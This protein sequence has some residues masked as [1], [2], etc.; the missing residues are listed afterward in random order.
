MWSTYQEYPRKVYA[1]LR[2]HAKADELYRAHSFYAG[3]CLARNNFLGVRTVRYES[4]RPDSNLRREKGVCQTP[5]V[6]SGEKTACSLLERF[7]LQALHENVS[8]G[9][10]V[11]PGM[12]HSDGSLFACEK[13]VG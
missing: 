6:E 3:S 12:L 9:R 8:T 4:C 13:K 10:P 2:R 1:T 11:D 7:S 5:S